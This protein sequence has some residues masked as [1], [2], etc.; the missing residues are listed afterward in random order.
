[1]KN[2]KA[3]TLIELLVV[4]LIIGI[5]ASV[6]LPQ[7]QKAVEKSKGVQALT[8]MRSISQGVQLYY[9]AT[10]TYPASLADLDIEM[11]PSWTDTEHVI[12]VQQGEY[13]SSSDWALQWELA[14]SKYLRIE[15]LKGP[16]RGAGFQW[17]VTSSVAE[18][19]QQIICIEPTSVIS[20]A[21]SYCEKLFKGTLKENNY[22]TRAY[23]LP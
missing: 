9:M 2:N 21:G 12:V 3:F 16:Y 11:P 1:M 10:G 17:T 8:L 19:Q 6:A 23:I 13:H 15:R 18:F 7:Y 4:V 22:G 20:Q 14:G 5:L